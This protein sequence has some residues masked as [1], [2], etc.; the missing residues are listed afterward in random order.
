MIMD[1]RTFIRIV[2]GGMSGC[3]AALAARSQGL[4]VALIQDRPIFGGNASD[5]VRVHTIGIPGKGT[6]II[7]TIVT[8]HYPNGHADAIVAQQKRE[9]TMRE[10]GVGLFAHHIAELRRLIGYEPA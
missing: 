5:E 4:K 10:S 6:K 1:R 9:A 2:G 3:G 7:Q 8:P